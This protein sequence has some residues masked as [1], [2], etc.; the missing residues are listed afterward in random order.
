VA[1]ARSPSYPV[2]GLRE[3]IDRVTAIYRKDYQSPIP[4]SVAVEHMGY[5]G[6]SGKSLGVL[7]ALS[8]YNLLEGRG[9]NTRVTDLA[10][11]IIAHPVGVP[12][13][14]EA[15]KAAAIHPGLFAD[16]EA[17]FGGKGSDSAI[18]AYL[19][20][21]K[22]IPSAADIA[23][24]AYRETKQL[25]EEGLGTNDK[26]N[27]QHNQIVTKEESDSS[28]STSTI[29]QNVTG[30]TSTKSSMQEIVNIRVAKDCAIK[31]LADGPYTKRSIEALVKNLQ[32]Q[33]ELGAYDDIDIPDTASPPT[34]S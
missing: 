7:A 30:I 4:R 3:A 10:V 21:E 19:L 2:I 17:R 6:L 5:R 14:V 32:L 11:Q 26:Y 25:L 9:D 33:L 16:L 8:R 20:T 27:S 24:R 18:R 31:L 13:R 15:I 23:L 12:E 34:Q 28:L 1:K 29:S 22:F